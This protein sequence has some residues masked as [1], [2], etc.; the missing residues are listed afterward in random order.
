LTDDWE[1]LVDLFPPEITSTTRHP[2]MVLWS[3]KAHTGV[4]IELT[5]P[6]EENIE[7]AHE[8]KMLKYQ[9]LTSDC[10]EK[11]WKTWCM[12]IEVGCRGFAGQSLWRCARMLG[13][14]GKES[15]SE[16]R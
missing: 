16:K 14:I 9:E 12:A 13:I 2:D 8:R 1:L 7:A 4:I 15:P 3:K 11:G 5:I 6:W 10:R